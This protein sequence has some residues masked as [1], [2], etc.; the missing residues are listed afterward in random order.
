MIKK[1][2][3]ILSIIFLIII[4]PVLYL[5]LIGV[6]TEKFN[7]DIANRILDSNNKIKLDL[8]SITT[9]IMFQVSFMIHYHCYDSK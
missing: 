5:S 8:K 4:L 6:K 2:I 3:K 1:L 9:Y 7:D